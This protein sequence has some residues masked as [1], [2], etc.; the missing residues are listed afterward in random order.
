MFIQQCK[1]ILTIFNTW[2]WFIVTM[3]ILYAVLNFYKDLLLCILFPKIKERICYFRL[4]NSL[5]TYLSKINVFNILLT[6]KVDSCL[7]NT[8]SSSNDSYLTTVSKISASESFKEKN[9]LRWDSC[10]IKLSVPTCYKTK[11]WFSL[12][13]KEKCMICLLSDT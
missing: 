2:T 12:I 5:Y 13:Q 10:N 6:I 9:Q 3:F 4:W 8:I 7:H 1:T 11:Q